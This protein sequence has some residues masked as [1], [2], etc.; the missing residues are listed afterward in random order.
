MICSDGLWGEVPA[1]DI[2]AIV[3]RASAD[4]AVR[5]LVDL[6]IENGGSDNVTVQIAIVTH[7]EGETTEGVT[8]GGSDE[9]EKTLETPHDT[10]STTLPVETIPDDRTQ[11]VPILGGGSA[12]RRSAVAFVAGLAAVMFLWRACA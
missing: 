12:W 7:A 3:A 1:E 10:R 6:A 5:E 2:T 4:V 8:I 9:D 11:P